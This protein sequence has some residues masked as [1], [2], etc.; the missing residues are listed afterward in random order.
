M[1]FIWNNLLTM[2][3][4]FLRIMQLT[5]MQCSFFKL[6]SITLSLVITTAML[7]LQIELCSSSFVDTLMRSQELP[8]N[9]DSYKLSS[10]HQTFL[11]LAQSI[12]VIP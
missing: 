12:K 4:F 3:Q 2:Y 1:Q 8:W 10:W 5:S 7:L 6:L 11:N 9:Y